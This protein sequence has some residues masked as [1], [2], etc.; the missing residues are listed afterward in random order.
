MTHVGEQAESG[1]V[2]VKLVRD[3]HARREFAR[4]AATRTAMKTRR[5]WQ[6]W[7][8]M[9]G[10][11]GFAGLAGCSGEA[12]GNGAPETSA[13]MNQEKIDPALRL[14]V[15][16]SERR[17]QPAQVVAVLIRTRGELDATKRRTLE[18]QGARI[19]SV[20]GDV[21][22]ASVPVR[23]VSAIANLEFVVRVELSKQQRLRSP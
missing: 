3:F 23:A 16:Q 8:V 9:L 1:T 2:A 18:S 13:V 14:T 10:L 17:E 15:Q 22:T 20:M 19:G 5:V 4:D 21:L 12:P 6:L 7:T 11:A